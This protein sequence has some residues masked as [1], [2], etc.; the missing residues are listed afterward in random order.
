MA[1]TLKKVVG[2][3]HRSVTAKAAP[4]QGRLYRSAMPHIYLLA[5]LQDGSQERHFL[6][7]E[8]T[9]VVAPLPKEQSTLHCTETMGRQLELSVG[10]KQR[11]FV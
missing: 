8:I 4:S 5:S 10:T 9:P 2:R 1:L 11:I 3:R 6:H 7:I